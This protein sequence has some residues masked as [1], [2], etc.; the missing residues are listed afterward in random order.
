VAVAY[1]YSTP[2]DLV[3]PMWRIENETTP[4]NTNNA[5]SVNCFNNSHLK[6][7]RISLLPG[8]LKKYSG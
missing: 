7:A 2:N 5:F 1:A 8:L 4:P 3:S 6:T